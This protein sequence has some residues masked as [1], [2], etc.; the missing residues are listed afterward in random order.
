VLLLIWSTVLSHLGV[1]TLLLAVVI[2]VVVSLR[3]VA[4]ERILRQHL[5]DYDGY[6]RETKAVIPF[7]L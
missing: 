7:V 5:A 2:T 3:I 4:E 6:A 1:W